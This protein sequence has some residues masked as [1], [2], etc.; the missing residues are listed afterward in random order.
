MDDR[1]KTAYA[2]DALTEDEEEPA[3]AGI[4]PFLE[5][6]KRHHR[7]G[8]PAGWKYLEQKRWALLAQAQAATAASP[9][10]YPKNSREAHA[11][12]VLFEVGGVTVP[13]HRRRVDGSIDFNHPVTPQIAALAE[14]PLKDAWIIL[15]RRQAGAWE[16]LLR[17]VLTIGVRRPIREGDR[18]PWPWPPSIDGK[19]YTDTTGPPESLMTESDWT[20][21]K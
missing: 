21:I 14:S 1:Q 16:A 4:A 6:L 3:L 12:I 8:V 15:S 10:N 5:D 9:T 7:K 2:A 17:E 19:I 18:A 13:R 20:N 11:I